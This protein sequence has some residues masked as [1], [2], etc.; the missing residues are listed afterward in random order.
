MGL[1]IHAHIQERQ[2]E[3]DPGCT[4]SYYTEHVLRGFFQSI[5]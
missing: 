5:D 4:P 1:I 3:C 2:G